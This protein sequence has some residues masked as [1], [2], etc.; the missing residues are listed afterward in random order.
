M[1][2]ILYFMPIFLT[3]IGGGCVGPN[4]NGLP[5]DRSGLGKWVGLG[6]VT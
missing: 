2:K 1:T 4:R 5:S 6:A 3:A